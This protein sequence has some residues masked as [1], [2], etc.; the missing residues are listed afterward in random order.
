MRTLESVVN[1]KIYIR[2]ASGW[3]YRELLP[4]DDITSPHVKTRER[5]DGSRIDEIRFNCIEGWLCDIYITS[6]GPADDPTTYLN[7]ELY[8]ES[9]DISVIQA[10]LNSQAGDGIL[11]S[12]ENMSMDEPL[13]IR[14]ALGKK[15]PQAKKAP[16]YCW[17]EQHSR[18]VP[19]LYTKDNPGDKPQWTSFKGPDGSVHWDK[20]IKETYIWSNTVVDR[21]RR[22][23]NEHLQKPA[24]P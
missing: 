10:R 13:A 17:L 12:I 6:R 2:P 11:L 5:E 7:V 20:K 8:D 4:T 14:V 24:T 18:T 22:R 21:M 15:L 1:P 3:F 19:R 23:I 9:A 16:T